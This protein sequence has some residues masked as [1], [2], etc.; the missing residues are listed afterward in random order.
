MK[1]INLANPIPTWQAQIFCGLRVG[2]TEEVFPIEKIYEVCQEYIDRIGWCVTVTPTKYIYKNGNELGA[3]IGI[4]Q[5]PR[6]PTSI[7]ILKEETIKLAKLL[8]ANL[9][10][11]RISIAFPEETVM[12][13]KE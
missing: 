9:K 7:D 13:E 1:E 3:I 4:I 5:Y 8:L 2:Y 6:F 10:Q 12:I 11:F